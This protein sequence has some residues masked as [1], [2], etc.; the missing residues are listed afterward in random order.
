MGIEERLRRL[1]AERGPK[2]CEERYCMRAPAFVEVA[3]YPDGSEERLGREPPP[4]C[5]MCP[6]R[7]GRER[8]QIR[9]VEVHRHLLAE[10]S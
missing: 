3:H 4:L 9:V 6:Y 1:E 8:G 10:P 2:L 5:R 7:D